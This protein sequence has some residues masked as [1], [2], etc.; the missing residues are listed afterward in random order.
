MSIV[1]KYGN[2]NLLKTSGSVQASNGN[3]LHFYFV[4]IYLKIIKKLKHVFL[5]IEYVNDELLSKLFF[6]FRRKRV[7]LK[8][9]QSLYRRGVAQSFPGI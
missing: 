1:L 2:L 9:K 3:A 6:I 7:K 4:I 8:V 5:N